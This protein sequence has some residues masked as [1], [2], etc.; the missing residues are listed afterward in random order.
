MFDFSGKITVIT[1]G[2]IGIGKCI[3]DMFS[4]A[5]AIACTIDLM[6]NECFTGYIADRDS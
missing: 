3:S 2:A 1:S 4:A 5:G 6:E